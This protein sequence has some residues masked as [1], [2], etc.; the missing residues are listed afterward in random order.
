MYRRNQFSGIA[1]LFAQSSDV[2][3]YGVCQRV[4]SG[5][6]HSVENAFA[7][8]YAVCIVHQ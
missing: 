6:P 8:D 7:T 2:Y 3:I 1:E 5:S 4:G